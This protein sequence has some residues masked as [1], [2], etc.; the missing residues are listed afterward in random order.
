MLMLAMKSAGPK[1]IVSTRGEAVA[2][3]FTF[4]SPSAFS[5]CASMP[6][7]PTSYPMVFSICVSSRSSAWTC[8]A[9]CTLG[10][11][12]QSRLAPAPST[13]SVTSR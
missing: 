2:M 3:A 12:M 1:M 11:M 8:S 7:R 9:V 4:T 13:T 10:S 6:I 5:I